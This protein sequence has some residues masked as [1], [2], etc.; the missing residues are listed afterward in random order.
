MGQ[1]LDYWPRLC[2]FQLSSG[3]Q[4]QGR[5]LRPNDWPRRWRQLETMDG[6]ETMTTAAIL[7]FVCRAAYRAF[8]TP[9]KPR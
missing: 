7:Y 3:D 4:L 6:T 8:A 5:T 1:I 9:G 2:D